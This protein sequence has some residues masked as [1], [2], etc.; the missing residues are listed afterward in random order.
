MKRHVPRLPCNHTFYWHFSTF[1]LEFN[2]TEEFLL[3]HPGL[4][5]PE[6]MLFNLFALK[7]ITTLG[8]VVLV[9]LEKLLL[10]NAELDEFVEELQLSLSKKKK[11][12]D[13]F[14]LL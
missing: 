11:N 9:L 13:W 3:Y 2:N 4:T 1:R 12:G 8:N 10:L 6:R 5:Y 7:S 14:F